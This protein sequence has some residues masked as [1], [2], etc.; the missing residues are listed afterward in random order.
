MVRLLHPDG[1]RWELHLMQNHPYL[2]RVQTIAGKGSVLVAAKHN[3]REIAAEHGADS[4][5]DGTRI[6]DNIVL[7]GRDSATGVAG[8][9]AK[10]LAS[11]EFS[12]P[13]CKNTVRAIEI[14]F[15]LHA[16]SAINHRDYF[17]ASTARACDYYGLPVLSSVVYLDESNLHCRWKAGFSKGVR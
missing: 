14:I 5:I 15:S 13:M 17:I 2:M 8:F 4:H 9:E 11:T 12:R 3:L 1:I 16:D 10:L 6:N 7:S